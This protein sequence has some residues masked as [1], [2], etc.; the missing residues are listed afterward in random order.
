VERAGILIVLLLVFVLPPLLRDQ[1]IAFDPF[2]TGLLAA[3]DWAYRTVLALAG[4]PERRFD[5]SGGVDA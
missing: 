1:G 4:H 5:G 3:F 2:G